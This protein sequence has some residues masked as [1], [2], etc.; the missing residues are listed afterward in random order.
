[1]KSMSKM[2]ETLNGIKCKLHIARDKIYDIQGTAIETVWNA[3]ERKRIWEME[4]PW[5]EPW[6]FKGPK[7]EFLGSLAI[8]T[9]CFHCRGCWFNPWC[10]IKI[11]QATVG[12]YI[13]THTHIHTQTYAKPRDQWVPEVEAWGENG[14]KFEE[15]MAKN[16]PYLMKT[17]KSQTKK[18]QQI[19][20]TGSMKNIPGTSWSNF[21]KS[22]TKRKP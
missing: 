16:T 21:S 4:R 18:V 10:G 7:W 11:L 6:D 8:R 15:M 20:S 3:T 17:I 2:R 22:V 5:S 9:G 1:M 12:G 14:R 19:S 13:Y